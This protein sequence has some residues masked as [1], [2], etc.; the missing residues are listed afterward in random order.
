MA[1]DPTLVP[2]LITNWPSIWTWIKILHAEHLRDIPLASAAARRRY[3]ALVHILWILTGLK[4]YLLTV[5]AETYGYISFVTSLWVAEIKVLNC[6]FE[7]KAS[8]LVE[9]LLS[10][11]NPSWRDKIIFNCG[12]QPAD[13]LNICLD[14]IVA[15]LQQQD[16][17]YIDL[18]SDLLIIA[19]V[20]GPDFLASSTS[21][22]CVA[23]MIRAIDQLAS[24]SFYVG[25]PM[26]VC[27]MILE[28]ALRLGGLDCLSDAIM[29]GLLPALLKASRHYSQVG[30]GTDIQDKLLADM[31]QSHI[32]LYL[33]HR[34]ALLSVST[35]L[36]STDI[37]SLKRYMPN[38]KF[39][40]SWTYL[41]KVAEEFM[42][43][44]LA[45]NVYPVASFMCGNSHVSPCESFI[46]SYL[47]PYRQCCA[48][49]TK[50]AVFF[51]CAGCLLTRFCSRQ[52]QKQAWKQSHRKLCKDVQRQHHSKRFVLSDDISYKMTKQFSYR[53]VC[54]F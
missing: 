27:A 32:T 50:E 16:L 40:E 3:D 18:T 34:S 13:V 31:L 33:I 28:G 5:I 2:D 46:P 41:E 23:I 49:E 10:I 54:F 37:K 12:G 21:T 53:P 52:C 39:T 24:T 25:E 47:T 22:R 43:R 6:D 38:N 45:Y 7:F 8:R 1:E 51:R 11:G 42:T 36:K 9:Q 29:A 48:V 44:K 30:R 17:D 20:E 14:R 19:R 15:H 35:S 4:S 26:N